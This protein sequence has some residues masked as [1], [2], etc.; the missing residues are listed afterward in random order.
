MWVAIC[1][2]TSSY[3]FLEKLLNNRITG[4]LHKLSYSLYQVN[5]TV[6]LMIDFSLRASGVRSFPIIVMTLIYIILTV[7]IAAVILYFLVDAPFGLL[8]SRVILGRKT[9]RK[10]KDD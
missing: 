8:T 6:I 4:L 10:S 7:Y 5:I 3:G 2:T 1:H 9:S